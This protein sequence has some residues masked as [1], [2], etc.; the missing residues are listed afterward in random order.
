[1]K[2]KYSLKA[3]KQL[4]LNCSDAN[5]IECVKVIYNIQ[6]FKPNTTTVIITNTQ[7]SEHAKTHRACTEASG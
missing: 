2:A 4:F 3:T 5:E 1:M 7:I 6:S